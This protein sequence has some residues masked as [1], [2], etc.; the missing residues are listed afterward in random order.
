MSK[1]LKTSQRR[2]GAILFAKVL[3]LI[4]TVEYAEMVLFQLI[5]ALPAWLENLLDATLLSLITTPFLWRWIVVSDRERHKAEQE[6]LSRNEQL[7]LATHNLE[8][9]RK[10]IDAFSIVATTDS[11]GVIT[12]VNEKFCKISG[13][14]ARELLGQ[15]HRVVNSGTHPPEFFHHMWST[16]SSGKVWR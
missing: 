7:E 13:Y 14:E 3:A 12:E 16:I 5:P 9:F 1:G 2:S 11:T 4:A 10:A 15:T 8:Q 6:T